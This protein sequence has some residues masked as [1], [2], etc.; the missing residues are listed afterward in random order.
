MAYMYKFRLL[1][2]IL[3]YLIFFK[4]IADNS[5]IFLKKIDRGFWFYNATNQEPNEINQGRIANVAVL[6]GREYILVYD[7]GPSKLFASILIK[8][9]KKISKKPIK[10]LVIS[11]RHFDHSFGIEAFI[12]EGA[13]IYFDKKEFSYFINEGPKINKLL[14]NNLGFNKDNIN[15]ENI[16][17]EDVFFLEKD[18]NLDL[19]NR[20]L[21]IKN[22]GNAHTEGDII[23]YDY[24]TKTYIVGDIIFEGRAA[25]FSDANLSLWIEK[26][27]S[28]LSLP[29]NNIVPGHGKIIKNVNK[30]QGTIMWLQFLDRSIKRSIKKGDMVAEIFEYPVPD[31]LKNLKM[32]DLTMRQGLKRQINLYLKKK[33]IE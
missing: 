11:H 5:E 2:F 23:V 16:R 29:W 17:Q 28:Q 9:I 6:I 33:N 31:E 30:L 13:T 27:K 7:S 21:L 18:L 14:I 24:E 3:A 32:R 8:Q 1:I 19:G 12:E 10:Y 15:F 22:I 25:A 20:K 26:I 4:C